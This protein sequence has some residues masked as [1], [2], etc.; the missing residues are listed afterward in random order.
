MEWTLS[1]CDLCNQ[2]AALASSESA[3]AELSPVLISCISTGASLKSTFLA[4]QFSV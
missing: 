2:C 3:E 4:W 1:C